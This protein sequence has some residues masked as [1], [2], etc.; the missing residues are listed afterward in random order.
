[1][2]EA[3]CE[4]KTR[5]SRSTV[6][7]PRALRAFIRE[8]RQYLPQARSE[9]FLPLAALRAETLFGIPRQVAAARMLRKR[10]APPP[11]GLSWEDRNDRD[12]RYDAEMAM[13]EVGLA[14]CVVRTSLYDVAD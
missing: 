6:S 14:P 5:R 3:R 8:V 9:H 11:R 12:D 13:T 1:M 4:A 10:R 7:E 2:S